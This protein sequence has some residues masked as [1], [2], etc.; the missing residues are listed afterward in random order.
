[1]TGGLI[2][3]ILMSCILVSARL[4]LQTRAETQSDADF[5]T[6]ITRIVNEIGGLNLTGYQTTITGGYGPD[7]LTSIYDQGWVDFTWDDNGS[8]LI[9]PKFAGKQ[10][11]DYSSRYVP[12]ASVMKTT[13]EYLSICADILTRYGNMF[14]DTDSYK[15]ASMISAASQAKNLTIDDDES[16]LRIGTHNANW[17]DS[18]MYAVNWYKKLPIEN[19]T[20]YY[21]SIGMALYPDGSLRDLVNGI[22]VW[23]IGTTH[24]NVS[25]EQA[26]N[27]AKPI[28]E[29]YARSLGVN[30]S[31]QE[32]PALGWQHD[33]NKTHG[34]DS[35]AIY[36]TWEVVCDFSPVKNYYTGYD[37]V[38]WADN[39]DVLRQNPL[40]Y[41]APTSNGTN[42][43]YLWVLI[44][45]PVAV[46]IVGG[47]VTF[48]K[49]R[50]K[51]RVE[52]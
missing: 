16:V 20:T 13:Q 39:G 35:L 48:F 37:V 28:V 12:N 11:C 50:Y 40:G 4:P 34:N 5:N 46:V 17:S 7:I 14:N 21:Q 33:A 32:P 24:L 2:A 43:I 36:P 45:V 47:L 18:T 49:R 30:A 25:K 52:K 19:S 27:L 38:L 8:H 44:V 41:Y 9:Q 26:V 42:P 23:R 51:N 3:C 10:L 1:L 29:T 15:A 22:P 31:F 6:T